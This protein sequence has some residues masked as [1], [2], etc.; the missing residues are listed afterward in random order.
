[1]TDERR[2]VT[3]LFADVVD[4]TGLGERLDPEDLRALLS[5]YFEVAREV[6]I[7]HGGTLEKFIGDAVVGVFGIPQAHGDDPK[8]AMDA[9]LELRDRL[10]ADAG[11]SGL[12]VRFGLGTGEV[13][14]TRGQGADFFIGDAVNVA[15]RLQ[16][17]GDDWMILAT[18]RTVRS[19]PAAFE[20]GPLR[21]IEVKGRTASVPA[22]D[23]R[24]RRGRQ[25]P[26]L[27]SRLPFR[28]RAD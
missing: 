22:Y 10:R 3:V 26:G 24:S 7:S 6:L 21:Q 8:R 1:M 13:V 14:T 12:K 2:V 23:V 15:A 9:A 5:R 4:S 25:Q 11:L 28:G 16:Q 27:R 19:A 18:E 20:V 17:A